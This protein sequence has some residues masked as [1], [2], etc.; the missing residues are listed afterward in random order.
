MQNF[1]IK[2]RAIFAVDRGQIK[3]TDVVREA[4][5][6]PSILST[7]MKNKDEIL[8]AYEGSSF[9]PQAKRMRQSQHVTVEKAVELWIREA[10]TSNVPLT[11]PIILEQ[12]KEQAKQFG[13]ADFDPGKN[14][15]G[16]FLHRHG[17]VYRS[18]VREE[19]AVETW[20]NTRLRPHYRI[21]ITQRRAVCFR[22]F[23][24]PKKNVCLQGRYVP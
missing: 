8:S 18:I 1:D 17:L 14:W 19:K 2:Y 12:A 7:W 23:N 20:K 24:Y 5:V 22:D 16:R 6:S 13:E 9:T 4:E 3:K 10:R 15:V 11:G 21:F